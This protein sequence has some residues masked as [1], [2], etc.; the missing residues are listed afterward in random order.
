MVWSL[1]ADVWGGL[2][3]DTLA[4]EGAPDQSRGPLSTGSG[5]PVPQKSWDRLAELVDVLMR[6]PISRSLGCAA[7]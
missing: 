7:A 2:V 1:V 5:R 6:G 3:R 4:S